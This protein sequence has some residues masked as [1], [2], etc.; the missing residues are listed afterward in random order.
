[1]TFVKFSNDSRITVPH[2]GRELPMRRRTALPIA[3]KEAHVP[4][5]DSLAIELPAEIRE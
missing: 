3:R 4:K 2:D 5:R 1:M